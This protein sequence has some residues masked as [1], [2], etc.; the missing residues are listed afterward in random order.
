MGFNDLNQIKFLTELAQNR[1]SLFAAL[2]S[3][4]ITDM[5]GNTLIEIPTSNATE[6][7]NFVNDTTPP[8]LVNF[9]IDKSGEVVVLHLTFS[10]T[11]HYYSVFPQ[12]FQLASAQNDL[13]PL[14]LTS[15]ST[16]SQGSNG[17]YVDITLEESVA[18]FLKLRVNISFITLTPAA[19]SDTNNNSV[20]AISLITALVAVSTIPDVTGPRLKT[21]SLNMSTGVIIMTFSEPVMG[22]SFDVTKVTLQNA[23]FNYT[24]TAFF[25]LTNGVVTTYPSVTVQITMTF[26]D[27]NQL[28]ALAPGLAS[29]SG[30]TWVTMTPLAVT[31]LSY[32]QLQDNGFAKAVTSFNSDII[33]PVLLSFFIDYNQ[34]QIVMSFSET[35]DQLGTHG[36]IGYSSL[37]FQNGVGGVNETTNFTLTGGSITRVNLLVLY[38]TFLDA[39]LYPLKHVSKDNSSAWLSIAAMFVADMTGNFL[40]VISVTSPRLATMLIP[41]QAHLN[42]FSLNMN[43]SV[44]TLFMSETVHS[45]TFQLNV[46][47]LQNSAVNATVAYTFNSLSG[48]FASGLLSDIISITLTLQSMLAIKLL[49]N[50]ATFSGN[51]FISF[52]KELVRY[53]NGPLIVPITAAQVTN[54]I[55][56]TIS[57]KLV[58]YNVSMDTGVLSLLFDEIID[59]T[60][61]SVTQ[62][63]FQNAVNNTASQFYTLTSSSLLISTGDGLVMQILLGTLALNAIKVQGNLVTGLNNTFLTM[64]SGAVQDMAS[65]PNAVVPVVGSAALPVTQFAADVTKP[66]VVSF[67]L[68]VNAGTLFISFDEPARVNTAVVGALVLQNAAS[69]AFSSFTLTNGSFTNVNGLSIMLTL[70]VANLNEVKRLRSLAKN[71]TSTFLQVAPTFIADMAG[72]AVNDL[73]S[74]HAMPCTLANYVFDI[75]PPMLLSFRFNMSSGK[76]WLTFDETVDGATITYSSFTF[77]SANGNSSYSL[78]GSAGVLADSTK[79]V[80]IVSTPD[81]DALKLNTAL[82]RGE[83]STKLQLATSTVLDMA[84]NGIVSVLQQVMVGGF[85][86]DL[87]SPNLLMFAVNMDQ[88]TITLNFDEPVN[89]NSLAITLFYL[90]GVMNDTANTRYQLTGGNTTSVNGRQVVLQMQISD[91]NLIKQNTNLFVSNI[92]TYLSFALGAITDMYANNAVVVPFSN[93][94]PTSDFIADATQPYIWSFGL[95]M[96]LGQLYIVFS[97]TMRANSFIFTAVTLQ[98]TSSSVAAPFEVFTLTGGVVLSTI[99]FTNITIQ[100]T[101]S[102]LNEMKRRRV[103]SSAGKSFLVF[104]AGGAK[105]MNELPVHALT[106]GLT[107]IAVTPSGFVADTTPPQLVSY[108][109]SL[110]SWQMVMTF[111]ETI[112]HNTLA[113][114]PAIF[115]MQSCAVGCG[116]FV[117]LSN[118]DPLPVRV[119]GTVMTITLLKNNIDNLKVIVGLVDDVATTFIAFTSAMIADMVGN[120][121]VPFNQTAALRAAAFSAD[122]VSPALVSFSLN[123]SVVPSVLTMSFS[124][125]IN[126]SSVIATQLTFQSIING[127]LPHQEFTLRWGNISSSLVDRNTLIYVTLDTRDVNAIAILLQLAKSQSTTNLYFPSTFLRDMSANPITAVSTTNAAAAV[128][129]TADVTKPFLI[130]FGINMVT[131]A[132]I[133]SWSESVLASSI[134]GCTIVFQSSVCSSTDDFVLGAGVNVTSGDGVNVSFLIHSSDLQSIKNL[135][136]VGHSALDTFLIINPSTASDMAL[137]PNVQDNMA[138]CSGVSSSYFIAD[139]ELPYISSYILDMSFGVLNLTFSK[140]V[141]TSSFDPTSMTLQTKRNSSANKIAFVDGSWPLGQYSRTLS[142]TITHAQFETMQANDVL[143]TSAATTFLTATSSLI[144]DPTGNV[145]VAILANNALQVTTFINDTVSPSLLA[146]DLNFNGFTLLLQFNEVVRMSSFSPASLVLFGGPTNLSIAVPFDGTFTSLPN[147]NYVVLTLPVATMNAIKLAQICRTYVGSIASDCYLKMP[148]TTITDMANNLVSA[149][150]VNVNL[151]SVRNYYPDTVSPVL[152]SF[153]SFDF[154]TGNVTLVFVEPINFTSIYLSSVSFQDAPDFPQNSQT[155]SGGSVQT[156][157]DG[158]TVS[159]QL[160]VSD[161]NTIKLSSAICLTYITC[162]IRF[163]PLFVDD[164]FGNQVEPVTIGDTLFHAQFSY[165]FK[166]TSAPQL[167]SYTLSLDSGDVVLTF[168]EPVQFL[169]LTPNR[170]VLSATSAGNV[171]IYAINGFKTTGADGLVVTFTLTLTDLLAI[172]AT[173]MLASSNS[174]TWLK[175]INVI[176]DIAYNKGN[177]TNTAP[178][179]FFPDVTSPNLVSFDVLDGNTDAFQV[180][181]DE[182]VALSSFAAT[183]FTLCSAPAILATCY[184]LSSSTTVIA[185]TTAST[186][187]SIQITPS[188]TDFQY[189]KLLTG[190]WVSKATAYIYVNAG[191]IS[192]R[193]GNFNAALA[194]ST[195]LQANI[196]IKSTTPANLISFNLDMDVGSVTMTFDGVIDMS[197][198]NAA[199]NL[200]VLAYPGAPNSAAY[201]LTGGSTTSANGYVCVIA[202]TASDLLN[203]K[204]LRSVARDN[205]STYIS[206]IA[207]TN[208]LLKDVNQ[209]PIIPTNLVPSK[210]VSSYTPDI[211]PPLVSAIG[212]NM[213]TR[214]L[215]FN[216]TDVVDTLTFTSSSIILQ[217]TV[218]ASSQNITYQCETACTVA[219]IDATDASTCAAMGCA[220]GGPVDYPSCANVCTSYPCLAGCG[221][222]F[223]YAPRMAVGVPNGVL[224]GFTGEVTTLQYVFSVDLFNVIEQQDLTGRDASSSFIVFNSSFIQDWALNP[225]IGYAD[226]GAFPV[227]SY[228]ADTSNG[229]CL[230]VSLNMNVGSLTFSFSKIVRASTFDLSQVTIS[231]LGNTLSFSFTS[232]YYS[233]MND[234]TITAF[235]TSVQLR[236]LRNFDGLAVQNISSFITFGSRLVKDMRGNTIVPVSNV[237]VS[238]FT[239]D[240]T[241]PVLLSFALD[242]SGEV[243]VLTFDEPIRLN[244]TVYTAITLF[245]GANIS[246]ASYYQLTGGSIVTT[247]NYTFSIILTQYDLNAIKLIPGLAISLNT[248]Y[249]LVQSTSFADMRGNQIAAF[250]TPI[251]ASAFNPDSIPPILLSYTFNLDSLTVTFSFSESMALNHFNSSALT[252]QKSA[253]LGS[254]FYVVPTGLSFTTSD[255][256]TFVMHLTLNDMY[257]IKE[258]IGLGTISSLTYISVTPAFATDTPVGNPVTAILPSAGKLVAGTAVFDLT[259]PSVLN[260]TLD[261]DLRLVT[262]YF[263]DIINVSTFNF[264]GLTLTNSSCS[265]CA[266]PISLSAATFVSR[267]RLTVILALTTAQVN[268]INLDRLLARSAVNTYLSFPSTLVADLAALPVNAIMSN[269]SLLAS[270]YIADTISPKLVSY[271]VSMDTG[272]LSLLFDEIIDVTQVSVTQFTFQNAVNNTASQF[273]TLTSSSLLISTGDGLVMQILLGTLALN[274]IKVQGNLVTG[275]NNTFLTMTSGA[276]QDMASL[277]NAV[278][279]VVGSAALPVTQFAAD[280]TKPNVVSFILDVNAGTLFIS[281]DE[282][283]RVN[284]AVV[285]ALV[286]QNAAS[287]AFSSFTLTN[288]S[289]TN[290]NGLSIMLTLSVANLNEVKRLRSLAK[291]YTSTFL[292]VAPTFIADMAGNAVNDLDSSHAMPC[293]LANYVFDITPPMLLSFRFNMSSGKVWLTFDETVDGATITY[294]S[295]TFVSANGN[296]SYSLIGSAGVLADSTKFVF[297]VSTPDMDALKLNTALVRG[298][299]STKLQ[300]ATSTVLDMASN[301]IVSVLQQVMVGGFTL[302]LVSPN[303]LMFAVNMD[304]STITLNFDEPVNTNSLAITLFYLQGVMNDTANT[305]Y[306]LTGGNTTS[307]NGRQVVLQMQIS[308]TNLIKQNTNLFVSNITTYLSFA[309]GAITDMYANNAVVVPFS[310]AMPTSDFIADATQPYI[311]SFGLNMN[312]GQL[313]IVFSGTMR[314]NSFIFTA[315]TLQGTSSSVAAPFEVFTLTGGVV[316]ST[317]NFTNITIQLTT[318]DLNEM[319]RRRVGSSAGKSFLVFAAGGAKTMNELPVHALT[320]GLTSIAVTPSGFVADT[321]PPQL[322]SY[323]FSLDSW[324]MVMT[325]TETI[326]H[327]TL[328][329]SPAIFRMQSCAVGCGL[330][331]DLSNF[332]PL[333]VRVDG[334]VMTITLLKNNIDNLKVIVG[335]VDDVATTFIA[336]TS[337]MIADM[338]GNPIVPFNQTAALRAAAF[339]ADTVSPALV[340]FSLNMSVVPS[341]LTMSFSEAI[342]VSSVIATQLTFQSIINGSLPHQEFTLRW[343]NISSSLVDRNTLIYV[344]LD[345]RDVNAI[346]ILLQLAKSQSTTNLYFPSTFLRDMSANPITAVSTTNAAAAVSYA[347]DGIAPVLSSFN[348]DMSTGDIWL[349]FSKPVFTT[350]FS[351]S[352]FIIQDAPC[353]SSPVFQIQ[354]F[355]V[356][357]TAPALLINVRMSVL[358][359]N[360][361]HARAPL[362][363]S[364]LTTYISISPSTIADTQLTSNIMLPVTDCNAVEVATFSP[365]TVRPTVT[366]VNVNMNT[367]QITVSFSKYVNVSTVNISAFTLTNSLLEVQSIGLTSAT[368]TKTAENIVT[369]SFNNVNLNAIKILDSIGKINISTFL[370]FTHLFVADYSSNT[371]VNYL[372][373]TDAVTA[374]TIP[375]TI[376][377]FDLDM[378]N[379]YITLYFDEV[380]RASTINTALLTLQNAPPRTAAVNL[381]SLDVSTTTNGLTVTISLSP[382]T[383]NLIKTTLTLGRSNTSSFISFAANMIQD[384]NANYLAAISDIAA[385]PVTLYVSNTARPHL[386][387]FKVDLTTEMLYCTFNE[388]VSASSLNVSGFRFQDSALAYVSTPGNLP[389]FQ[390]RLT[391]GY[392]VSPDGIYIAV[393]LMTID[394]NYLKKL[395]SSFRRVDNTFLLIDSTT[396]LNTFGNPVLP[397]LDGYAKQTSQF[398]TDT[399]DPVLSSYSVY[400]GTYGPPLRVVLRFSETVNVSSF[401]AS[402]LTFQDMSQFSAPLTKAYQLTGGNVVPLPLAP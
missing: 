137:I 309:L 352:T 199:G 236:S 354:T 28:K 139:N 174:T 288:G 320:D 129:Y 282:P 375:P 6:V 235:F 109:F 176:Q 155:L 281:F 75:T 257:D 278:V 13:L 279:P 35:M 64:T 223:N 213:N 55:A 333:P 143:A 310:N 394:L 22:N 87:V 184:T 341:V 5:I 167:Q 56:D 268:A 323:T 128:S 218:L 9:T 382:N 358:D 246:A 229:T 178:S 205:T 122:T 244:A 314:A 224:T 303:L 388:A 351:G 245:S 107:S 316:L 228:T 208:G 356:V 297:I 265:P 359:L 261:L 46:L 238:A 168:N 125:A 348:I 166:D 401:D 247:N 85:T 15:A 175:G 335:L 258:H 343:G 102:D 60:Q 124:E 328:A 76:V 110:D 105:T 78:I 106:D 59:V 363:S 63:T 364:N 90:Q 89:T 65:L 97:G 305:R 329:I 108:T 321:T 136:L 183:N 179:I 332:D 340:S 41:R 294:S 53:I 209:L 111:T 138:N 193:A 234:L 173:D 311:W 217:S 380:I 150:N 381:T 79:F 322:V 185:Y 295:F 47:T 256:L 4:I 369:L 170:F 57:P 200:Q 379:G 339:S 259:R 271:N 280:V 99:N 270:G 250:S 163:S 116:L 203:I 330:F 267:T 123:M 133:L 227:G 19:A 292:Q 201:T 88:S 33:P 52:P 1:S 27:L 142:Y 269:N 242:M 325:F 131:G 307:V 118:F 73:D 164:M 83:A 391:S 39:D 104:A 360:V 113:I 29:A 92:T 237:M 308:D 361:L 16:T 377:R 187:M 190:L 7:S 289:F 286:L 287:G 145:L 71:Y 37:T 342:N 144:S 239:P 255:F 389:D 103:G 77:V 81:M 399:I 284:T 251:V 266:N 135:G 384:M 36:V 368:V 387:S 148:S 186:R 98:G 196:F 44:L 402:Q 54:Y 362:A 161:L 172:K 24:S 221:F 61:V 350:S 162:W 371:V 84:S 82:V 31:D 42:T 393:K 126:V 283:A 180:S 34:S 147:R 121:I 45:D 160:A 274:A 32:N 376:T 191:A 152:S 12:Y 115:R 291:N 206:T 241:P 367:A 132:V 216:F 70:S 357:S 140:V 86:L 272:V 222:R 21:F 23:A 285:G 372:A 50:L 385:I 254:V 181:F 141:Y 25:T 313:Y 14:V 74:S 68:D 260:F 30:N 26:A 344:T 301:G 134:A 171:S 327:N 49:R 38:I 80:F 346:A 276:V 226:G 231:N 112:D 253:V 100:L 189:I 188:H 91:T 211:Q 353:H 400:M 2:K 262:L 119:D 366:Y 40:P 212:L 95:N 94:M 248:T 318:S 293:T 392:T 20:V 347:T 151:L 319:K 62:F 146:F 154:N 165:F 302:D 10:E 127:S 67:I 338:V 370:H 397:L 96:N 324:Q 158:L 11:I 264:A 355:T 275:L 378:L 210:A 17:Q 156:V 298:E 263:N 66:N 197:S 72:N 169:S 312:L 157:T 337:A 334:T 300:L 198:L 345:T 204:R 3:S 386:V 149:L 315:V 398:I 93:A 120:P 207:G 304:Q 299:A 349:S 48:S 296:S 225:V 290:V 130:S 202:M 51:T 273:Y 373:Q 365:D 194:P 396:I 249:M 159:F 18:N 233:T 326:D 220:L 43:T 331:V 58:S 69:G 395:I 153:R 192:D 230:G 182:P 232:G 177:M 252:I 277:P 219:F 215:Q 306:Q 195:A 114:S 243:L 374:D 383:F 390:Y 214:T 101:T 336:F 317:I 8:A 240:T 117:D